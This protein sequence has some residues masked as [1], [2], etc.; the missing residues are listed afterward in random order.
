MNDKQRLA[1]FLNGVLFI[2]CG[3]VMGSLGYLYGSIPL[4]G[5][6]GV[7]V[8]SGAFWLAI[9]KWAGRSA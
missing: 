2:V 5:I 1:F 9:A 4:I 8:V 3:V 7:F 6:G